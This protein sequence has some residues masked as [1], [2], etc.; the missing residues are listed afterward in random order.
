VAESPLSAEI[1]TAGEIARAPVME[2]IR[3]RPGGIAVGVGLRMAENICYYVITTFSITYLTQVVHA[4]RQ[5]ALDAVLVGAIVQA[6]AIVAFGALSDRIGRRPV[7]AIGAA[8]TAI[9]AFAFFRLLDTGATPMIMLAIVVGLIGHAAM[10]GP[11]AAFLAEL[12]PTKIR[13][14]AASLAYQG[15]SILAGSLA[16][17]I[18]VWL[19]KETGSSLAIS[20]Y[21]AVAGAISVAAALVARETRGKSFAEIDAGR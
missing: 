12:F 1:E 6:V 9:W 3:T 17:I 7:Y 19:L 2:A 11:Q 14:S 21:V 16:P 18:A 4:S 13:Y 10:Y 8:G 5:Q 20:I 15:T